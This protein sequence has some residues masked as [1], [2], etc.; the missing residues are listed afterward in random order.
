MPEE[1]F[2][3]EPLNDPLAALSS[4]IETDTAAFVLSSLIKA[5]ANGVIGFT[6]ITVGVAGRPVIEMGCP[7]PV[8]ANRCLHPVF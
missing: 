7:E 1:P 2:I 5:D 4:L 3:P 8:Q 6:A